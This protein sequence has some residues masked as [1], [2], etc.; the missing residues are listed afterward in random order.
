[1][2]AVRVPVFKA[3]AA[4]LMEVVKGPVFANSAA[5]LLEVVKGPV[6]TTSAA[7]LMD[8]IHRR[9]ESLCRFSILFK[10]RRAQIRS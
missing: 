8:V 5:S 10:T 4:S 1:M 3:S 7:S 9:Y 6:F 2:E